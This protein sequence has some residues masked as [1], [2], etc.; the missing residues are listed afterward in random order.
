MQR[1]F[2]FAALLLL[3]SPAAAAEEWQKLRLVAHVH[4]TMS[5]GSLSFAEVMDQAKAAQLD[6]VLFTDSLLRHWEYG[7][8]PLR[9]LIKKVIEQPSILKAGAENYLGDIRSQNKAGG[10]L[11]VAGL[12]AAPFYYWRRSPFDAQGGE[13]RDWN[14][15]LL[16]FGL[17]APEAFEQLPVNDF[18]PYHGDYQGKPYQQFIDAATAAGGV[19][20]WAHPFIKHEGRHGGINDSTEAYPH[21]LEITNGYDGFAI[22]YFG[23]L[24]ALEPGLLWDSLLLDYVHGKRSKPVWVIGES[25]WRSAQERSLAMVVTDVWVDERSPKAVVSALREGRSWASIRADSTAP[26]L[27]AFTI[28]D[29]ASGHTAISGNHMT[30]HGK[31]SIRVALRRG[32][33]AQSKFK[34]TLVKNGAVLH[35]EE[36]TENKFIRK[37]T[38]QAPSA[39]SFYRLNV[40]DVSGVIYTNPIFIRPSEK[41]KPLR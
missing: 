40:E 30:V 22:T 41:L 39:V 20:F 34:V 17:D 11:A 25:D 23:Y 4:T 13:I 2:F 14:Q 10:P 21:L 5:T 35:E 24:D 27:E 15:H 6:G 7:I 37:W 32:A 12:E 8:W 3:G 29:E 31:I 26:E 33:N 16:V 18:D 9:G 19:V 1:L 36:L 28:V 38:D